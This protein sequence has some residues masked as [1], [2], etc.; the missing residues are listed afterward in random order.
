MARINRKALAE[1]LET[2]DVFADTTTYKIEQFVD[3]FFGIISAHVVNG[4]DV[5]IPGF[6]KFEKYKRQNGSFK[7]KFTAFTDFKLAL[8]S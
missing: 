6:G 4:D 1:T 8:E 7:P 2:Y 5:A 3:D